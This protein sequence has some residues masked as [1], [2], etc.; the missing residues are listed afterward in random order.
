MDF[1]IYRKQRPARSKSGSEQ[2][3]TM[4]VVPDAQNLSE[5][6]KR[7]LQQVGVGC[8]WSLFVSCQILFVSPKT[9]F[10]T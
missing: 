3:K 4:A 5:F 2:T 8:L 6:I 7:V 9:K 10:W 1:K